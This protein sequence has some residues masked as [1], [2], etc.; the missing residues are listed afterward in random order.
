MTHECFII[1]TYSDIDRI[2]YYLVWRFLL[3]QCGGGGQVFLANIGRECIH[4][5]ICMGGDDLVADHEI[6]MLLKLF[7]DRLSALGNR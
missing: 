3:S 5:Y 1:K 2:I 4:A 6:H 7:W